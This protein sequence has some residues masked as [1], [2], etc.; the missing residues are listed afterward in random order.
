MVPP[1][2]LRSRSRSR[3][4]GR[5]SFYSAFNIGYI[6]IKASAVEFVQKWKDACYRDPNAWDQVLFA[7]VL[8]RGSGGGMGDHNLQSM[9]LKSDGKHVMAGVLPVSL[10]AS[11][12]TF[13]VSR[14]A[15]LMHEHPF[16]VHTTFQYGGAQGKVSKQSRAPPFARRPPLRVARRAPPPRP[17]PAYCGLPSRSRSAIDCANR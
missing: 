11:G 17:V 6:W 9:Y 16:M 14:M 10:F 4:R 15:H 13:F 1:W 12:H 3:S 7:S 5:R 8:R 2:P